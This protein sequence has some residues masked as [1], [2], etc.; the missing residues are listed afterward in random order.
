MR[1]GISIRWLT[2]I[3]GKG[4]VVEIH[5]DGERSGEMIWREPSDL[6]AAHGDA[7]EF[8]FAEEVFDQWRHL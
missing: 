8:L 3:G 2:A 7:F 4:Q 5:R 6:V 1:H